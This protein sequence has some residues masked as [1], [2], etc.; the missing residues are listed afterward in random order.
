MAVF[1]CEVQH[2]PLL[3]RDLAERQSAGRA[4]ECDVGHHPG[5]AGLGRRNQQAHTLGEY[6]FD[7]PFQRRECLLVEPGGGYGALVEQRG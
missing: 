4:G 3:Y 1:E 7:G 6:T 2:G 5:L